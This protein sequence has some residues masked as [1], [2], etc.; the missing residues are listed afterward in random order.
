[1]ATGYGTPGKD[2]IPNDEWRQ[3]GP[4]GQDDGSFPADLA[5]SSTAWDINGKLSLANGGVALLS[6]T[7]SAL[8][9]TTCGYPR[10][11]R[12][13]PPRATSTR[14]TPLRL[15]KMVLI[16][17]RPQRWPSTREVRVSRGIASSFA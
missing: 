11:G 1:M 2:S 5:F 9:V 7:P 13:P 16:H 8:K 4:N 17:P 14:S 3:Q 15:A 6:M 12:L 10:E